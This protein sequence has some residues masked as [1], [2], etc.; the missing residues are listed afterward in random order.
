MHTWSWYRS[1]QLC[2]AAEIEVEGCLLLQSPFNS[3]AENQPWSC[4]GLCPQTD[5]TF[6]AHTKVS[7]STEI[8]EATLQSCSGT[9]SRY[10]AYTIGKKYVE[11]SGI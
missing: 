2:F 5:M 3:W 4:L 6:Y 7:K 10:R 1:L 11:Q 8:E 9:K